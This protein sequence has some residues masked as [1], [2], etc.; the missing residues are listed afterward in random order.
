MPRILAAVTATLLLALAATH[1]P[2]Q[3]MLE[4]CEADIETYCADVEPGDGRVV[5]CL[6]AHSATI[7]DECHAATDETARLLERFFDRVADV[8]EACSAE[9]QEHCADVTVGGGRKFQCLRD[10]GPEL[11][12]GCSGML[13]SMVRR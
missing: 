10:L 7:S 5:S 6:Y 1:A 2:A 3:G 9:L 11:S 12:A 4:R 8:S 13:E